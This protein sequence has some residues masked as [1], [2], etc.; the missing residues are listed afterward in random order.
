MENKQ[1][2]IPHLEKLAKKNCWGDRMEKDEGVY[3]D[4][5]AGGNVDDA[6]QGGVD[7]GETWLARD[8]LPFIKEIEDVALN[9]FLNRLLVPTIK[10]EHNLLDE[11]ERLMTTAE[12]VEWAL[13]NLKHK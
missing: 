7:T 2:L 11:T 5:F 13:N 1:Q 12:R 6:Y 3:I 8:I 10:I 4:D 9:G